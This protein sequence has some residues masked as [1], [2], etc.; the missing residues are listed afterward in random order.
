[1][2]DSTIRVP[3]DL[4]ELSAATDWW[5][6]LAVSKAGSR[7][8]GSATLC[9]TWQDLSILVTPP[10]D[11][12][13]GRTAGSHT[14]SLS[15]IRMLVPHLRAACLRNSAVLM[16]SR[17][18]LS[19]AIRLHTI[20][21]ERRL[22]PLL[23]ITT[24]ARPDVT[25][26]VV[27]LPHLLSVEHRDVISD[28]VI[29]EVMTRAE[30][31]QWLGHELPDQGFFEAQLTS[32]VAMRSLARRGCLPSGPIFAKVASLLTGRN[33]SIRYVYQHAAL[34]AEAISAMPAAGH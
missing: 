31:T 16:D 33:M 13:T 9:S 18:A 15:E 2:Y 3:A 7:N 10:P 34:F 22:G 1:M 12:N 8:A 17:F 11:G 5:A 28:T 21:Q 30:A 4:P 23:V 6:A 29:W 25:A 24:A 32:L 19:F 27:R 20:R 26:G 14:E